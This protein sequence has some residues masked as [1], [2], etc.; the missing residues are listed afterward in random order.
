M[1]LVRDS[2]VMSGAA[3]TGVALVMTGDGGWSSVPCCQGRL[4]RVLGVLNTFPT[5]EIFFQST[6]GLSEHDPVL[7]RGPSSQRGLLFSEETEP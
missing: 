5:N 7:S 1:W 3:V 2:R 4:L 6:V